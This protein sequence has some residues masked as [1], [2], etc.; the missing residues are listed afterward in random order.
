M[1]TKVIIGLIIVAVLATAG[2]T[3]SFFGGGSAPSTSTSG[4]IVGFFE[5]FL[6][7]DMSNLMRLGVIAVIGIFGL[8]AL[9]SAGARTKMSTHVKGHGMGY[10]TTLL[11]I[12]FFLFL[13]GIWGLFMGKSTGA[14]NPNPAHVGPAAT[15]GG[16]PA[17]TGSGT[18]S[19]NGITIPYSDVAKRVYDHGVI[20]A[21]K[22]FSFLELLAMIT[23]VVIVAITLYKWQWARNLVFVTAVIAVAGFGMKY[24]GAS[25]TTIGMLIVAAM[26]L[27]AVATK[28]WARALVGSLAA[29]AIIGFLYIAF[30]P[31]VLFGQSP[32]AVIPNIVTIQPAPATSVA[33]PTLVP[34]PV[35][36]SHLYTGLIQN[37]STY[38]LFMP[39][40]VRNGQ[41]GFGW[42]VIAVTSGTKVTLSG[43]ADDTITFE[44]NFSGGTLTGKWKTNNG[45]TGTWELTQHA[46]LTWTG[47][48]TSESGAST[49][50][51]L[52]R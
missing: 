19:T 44:G 11:I 42:D 29:V 22:P 20:F 45:H 36:A 25:N 51:E 13:P 41:K 5:S 35:P 38:G 33:T 2:L 43:S 10:F 18:T 17:A 1:L 26:A 31:Y 40:R 6:V 9:N 14:G 27:Y 15:G 7:G 49:A 39:E 52:R 24:F 32:Q 21:G 8:V 34:A 28:E 50:I 23:I 46:D 47:T 4:G 37:G 12:L 30:G 48:L 3:Y 16:G